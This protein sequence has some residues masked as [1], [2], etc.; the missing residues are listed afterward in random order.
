MFGYKQKEIQIK[1][2]TWIW[3][4]CF[5]YFW[6][7]RILNQ[8]FECGR[9]QCI[10]I[11]NFMNND[12]EFI[13]QCTCRYLIWY[14]KIKMLPGFN[15]LLS[16]PANLHDQVEDWFDIVSYFFRNLINSRIR[17]SRSH[18]SLLTNHVNMHAID[19]TASDLD[20]KPLH[21]SVL[22]Q[23]HCFQ[24]ST[25]NGSKY[26]TCRTAEEREKWIGR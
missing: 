11:R 6:F 4:P 2:I 9:S 12:V 17:S 21:S 5:Q 26:I 18:E 1:T 10:T 15:R 24:V 7:S 8:L 22:G 13:G 3:W 23:D 25:A 16:L 14:L 20:I 19:L